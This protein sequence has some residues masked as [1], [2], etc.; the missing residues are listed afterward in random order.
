MNW[1]GWYSLKGRKL[2][3][4]ILFILAYIL[5]IPIRGYEFLDG[6]VDTTQGVPIWAHLIIIIIGSIVVAVLHCILEAVIKKYV[7]TKKIPN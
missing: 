7:L 4:V 3:A 1:E 5:T 2:I 6:L